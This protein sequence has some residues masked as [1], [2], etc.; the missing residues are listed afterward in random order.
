MPI[1]TVADVKQ[2]F[3]CFSVHEEHRNFLRF[4][5]HEDN[6]PTNPLVEYRMTVHVFGNSPSPAI[7]TYCLRKAV[8]NSNIDIQNFVNNDFY[9]DDALV[10]HQ[11]SNEAVSLVKNTQAVLAESGIIL[12]KIASNSLEV[13]SE[14]CDEDLSSNLKD[15]NIKESSCAKKPWPPLGHER[16]Y[17]RL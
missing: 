17:I 2:M 9:V 1:A 8:A 15:V 10:S 6:I 4:F 13:V 11:T 16:R 14:F 5:W 12:H 7:A 3:Y